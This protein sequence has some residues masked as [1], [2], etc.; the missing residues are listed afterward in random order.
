VR[1]WD[2]SE[3]SLPDI[4]SIIM[5][6]AETGEQIYVDTHDKKFRRKFQEAAR[7]REAELEQALK[8]AGVDT[9]SLSTEEDLVRAIVR[10]AMLR[11][12]RRR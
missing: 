9:L 8:Q 7:Q 4:G 1:L 12:Q 11:K 6:D 3:L 2:P 10:F 5:E